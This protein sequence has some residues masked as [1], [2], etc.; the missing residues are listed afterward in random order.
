MQN[1]QV[2]SA[3]GKPHSFLRAPRSHLLAR[4]VGASDLSPL[5]ARPSVK[6][7]FPLGCSALQPAA[8]Y[9]Q[10]IASGSCCSK[11]DRGE[12]TKVDQ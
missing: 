12:P 3:G 2:S 7:N 9:N 10:Q 5:P 1:G 11:S 6:E 8:F 4:S